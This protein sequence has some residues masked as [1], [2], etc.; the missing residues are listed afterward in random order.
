M[1]YILLRIFASLCVIANSF[2]IKTANANTLTQ[3]LWTSILSLIL[4]TLILSTTYNNNKNEFIIN[5]KDLKEFSNNPF[6]NI[7]ALP[8]LKLSLLGTIS[9]II[10]III[11]RKIPYSLYVI[12]VPLYIVPSLIFNHFMSNVSITTNSLISIMLTFIGIVIASFK[13]LLNDFKK[14]KSLSIGLGLLTCY[15]VMI[16]YETSYCNYLLKKELNYIE[17]VSLQYILGSIIAIILSICYISINKSIYKSNSLLKY[18]NKSLFLLAI[19]SILSVLS[20][21]TRIDAM[22]K[23]PE[24]LTILIGYI[25]IPISLLISYL[26]LKENISYYK[27]IGSIL[28]IIGIS[29]SDIENHIVKNHIF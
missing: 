18:N 13:S 4:F 23:L 7:F 14:F 25:K 22:K 1:K 2:I 5:N 21:L 24:Y 19:V 3:V 28:I 20:N 26:F 10:N 27:I 12:L 8:I 17:L 9:Y 6:K 15:I 29:Y 11:L 16:A